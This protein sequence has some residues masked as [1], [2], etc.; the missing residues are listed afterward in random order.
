MAW[1]R[2]RLQTQRQQKLVARATNMYGKLKQAW[3]SQRL[4]SGDRVA[5]V[6]HGQRRRAIQWNI[7]NPEG[8]LRFAFR[9]LGAGPAEREGIDG[10]HKALALLSAVASAAMRAQA[11]AVRSTFAAF[12]GDHDSG[13]LVISRHYDGTP[14]RLRFGCLQEQVHPHARY[15][16]QDGQT[17]KAVPFSAF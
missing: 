3:D 7:F 10:T 4:R 1:L 15:L 9:S 11:S 5:D 2:Q 13:A 12:S 8:V 6:C 14:L 16:I 17:W